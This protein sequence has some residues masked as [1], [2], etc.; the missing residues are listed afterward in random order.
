MMLK[1]SIILFIVI[2]SQLYSSLNS[3][4]LSV[5]KIF[6]III[7]FLNDFRLIYGRPAVS[8]CNFNFNQ[9]SLTLVMK[10]VPMYNR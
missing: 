6:M 2:S 7:Y 10:M 5:I 1:G 4:E 3:A 8:L 9:W